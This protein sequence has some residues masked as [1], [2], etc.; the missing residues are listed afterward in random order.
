MKKYDAFVTLKCYLCSR[1][2]IDKKHMP[3]ARNKEDLQKFAS[4]NYSNLMNLISKMSDSQMNTPFDFS[5]D[6]KK[7]EAHWS[8]DKNV[9]DVLVHLYEWHVLLLNF[10]KNNTESKSAITFPFL[11]AQYSWKTYGEMN[12]EIWKRHQNTSLDDAMSLLADTHQKVIA[13]AET[14]SNEELFT[15]KYFPWTG[16]TDLGSYFVSSTSSH[17]DWAIKKI[18]QHCKKIS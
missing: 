9:R 1:K 2:L 13:L 12:V 4:E 17:Y 10:V 11:P 6:E 18:K 16:T 14:F 3:R 5:D 8:R 15:K 7:K